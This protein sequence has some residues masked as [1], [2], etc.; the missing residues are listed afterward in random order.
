MCMNRVSIAHAHAVAADDTSQ[1]GLL[2][3]GRRPILEDSFSNGS[4]DVLAFVQQNWGTKL[5]F[6]DQFSTG[7]ALLHAQYG[8]ARKSKTSFTFWVD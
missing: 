3:D 7:K 5:R 2:P 4:Y 6:E 1:A 8:K